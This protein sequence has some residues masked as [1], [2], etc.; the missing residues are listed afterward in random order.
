VDIYV[1]EREKQRVPVR[2]VSGW[3]MGS[4]G[5]WAEMDLRGP[6][7]IFFDFLFSFPVFLFEIIFKPHFDTKMIQ[8]FL[9]K[10][11]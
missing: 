1:S 8:T 2:S 10:F 3:A 4:F 6:L 9:E 11:S 5:C 7:S